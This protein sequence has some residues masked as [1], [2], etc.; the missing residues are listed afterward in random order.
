MLWFAFQFW[1]ARACVCVCVCVF[2]LEKVVGWILQLVRNVYFPW[3]EHF[4]NW[5]C[6][7][8]AFS[9]LHCLSQLLQAHLGVSDNKAALITPSP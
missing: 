1:G 2:G 4:W 7:A 3:P 5:P 8:P 6:M 9:D